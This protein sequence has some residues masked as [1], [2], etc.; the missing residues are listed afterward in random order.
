MNAIVTSGGLCPGLN[1]VVHELT[2]NHRSKNIIGFIKGYKGLLNKQYITLDTDY[3]SRYRN[4]GGCL[5]GSSRVDFDCDMISNAITDMNIDK[6]YVVGGNGSLSGAHTLAQTLRNRT[7][8]VGIPTTIDN[9]IPH[10]EA[11][12]GFHSALVKTLEAINS[13]E[14]ECN[15]Y[16]AIGIV[17]VMGRD[18]GFIGHYSSVCHGNV[19]I[20]L[21]PENKLNMTKF[22]DDVENIYDKKQKCLI[23]VSEGVSKNIG[24]QLYNTLKLHFSNVAFKYID[25]SYIVRTVEP[26]AYDLLYC[27]NLAKEA[28]KC[29]ETDVCVTNDGCVPLEKIYNKTKYLY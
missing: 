8:V 2:K 14:I 28:Y 15:A 3:T 6:L 22:L 25:P 1:C 11:S 7:Q 17:Q 4:T 23:V 16:D 27:T 13:I 9:D 19:D 24:E 5:L 10:V 26:C 20:T 18:S 12:F 21:V 29:K